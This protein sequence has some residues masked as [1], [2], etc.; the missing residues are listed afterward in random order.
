MEIEHQIYVS[1]DHQ[2]MFVNN[3]DNFFL[4][5]KL[6]KDDVNLIPVLNQGNKEVL[7]LTG[8]TRNS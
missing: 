5:S 6:T 4:E 7:Y 2:Q 8:F 1:K 3:H